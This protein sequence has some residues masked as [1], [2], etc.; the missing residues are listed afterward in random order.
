MSQGSDDRAYTHSKRERSTSPNPQTSFRLSALNR[1]V[2]HTSS[3]KAGLEYS[4]EATW[5]PHFDEAL[6]VS[7]VSM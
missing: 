1:P 7:K 3:T 4:A 5:K 6:L 2:T